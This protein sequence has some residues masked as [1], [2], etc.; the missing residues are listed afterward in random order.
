MH[1]TSISLLERLRRPAEHEAWTRFV[2]LLRRCSLRATQGLSPE[3]AG[4]LVQEVLTVLLQK[5]PEFQY[6]Q[7]KS[8]RNWLRTITLNKWRDFCR[9]RATSPGV[10]NPGDLEKAQSPDPSDAFA[11]AE[12]RQRLVARALEIMKSEFQPETWKACWECLAA[13]RPAAEVADELG[14]TANAVYLA[15]SRVLRRLREELQGLLD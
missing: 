7:E 14:L 13:D 8:F 6:D 1:T 5:L 4:D 15:K 11:E 12:Y 10:V 2:Q 9:R 3:D